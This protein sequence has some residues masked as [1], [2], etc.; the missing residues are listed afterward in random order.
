MSPTDPV[1]GASQA[2]DHCTTVTASTAVQLQHLA[3][4]GEIWAQ[5]PLVPMPGRSFTHHCRHM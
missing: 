2:K 5:V 4:G 3:H 1:Q